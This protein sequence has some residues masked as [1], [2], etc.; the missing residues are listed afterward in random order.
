M[1]ILVAGGAGYIG[2]HTCVELLEAGYDVVVVD[3]PLITSSER[4]NIVGN[5]MK[6]YLKSRTYI[7]SSWRADPRLD[8]PD[9]VTNT[10][11]F[12]SNK[13]RMKEV[14]YSYNGAF[15]GTGEGRVI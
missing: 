14:N 13:V 3:N 11:E 5:W 8:A 1:S 4:A 2:S 10:N 9:I 15:K 7:E 12:I 6:D